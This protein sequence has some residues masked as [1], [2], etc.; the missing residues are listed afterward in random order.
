MNEL[1]KIAIIGRPNVGKSTLFNRLAGRRMALVHDRPGV[2]RDRREAKGSLGDLDFA[3]VDTAGLADP[4][5]SQMTELMMAQSQQAI[6]Q[7][8]VVL[9]M[10]DGATG[11]TPHDHDLVDGLRRANTPIILLVNKCEGKRGA[12]GIA[13]AHTLGL[14]AEVI[15]ISAE[16]GLG[17]EELYDALCQ[18][19][20]P[21][22]IEEESANDKPLQLA[23]IG[24][25]NVGKSTLVNALIG[26]DRLITGD[27]PGVTRDAISVN[28]QYDGRQICLVDTAGVRKRARVSDVVE[29]L[30]V[31]D[32]H[33]TIRF[34]EVVV[35]VLDAT[36]A[37]EKQD[38]TLA[39]QVVKE[40]RALVVAVNKAD[41]IRDKNNYIKNLRLEID[42]H[43]S[44]VQNV[45]V[46]LISATRNKNL[47][48][49]MQAVFDI[50]GLWNARISTGELNR[51]LAFQTE[52][53]PPPAVKGRRIKL[54]YMTQAKTRPPTFA[55][56]C[57]QATELPA[58][59]VRYLTNRLRQDFDM[60]G[61]PIRIY[62]KSNQNPYV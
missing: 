59:Y 39:S 14:H 25:P 21:I 17:L 54:K 31:Q 28:W 5:E 35:I 32:A 4:E 11:V 33:N 56:F 7:A 50:Y 2:T 29:K 26:E 60:P 42:Q 15:A 52:A 23:I 45:P 20:K 58:S 24:R 30:S 34:A 8:N 16:H 12:Q 22:P 6:E 44:Q 40:G 57:S 47:S 37:L 27:M 1:P 55:L 10:I 62:L 51:W 13:D 3:I 61:I 41:L 9:F 36:C 46:V 43:L 38:L 19:I 18:H 53:H 49:L 48:G